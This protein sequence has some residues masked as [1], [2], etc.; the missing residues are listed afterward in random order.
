M[1]KRDSWAGVNNE[2]TIRRHLRSWITFGDCLELPKLTV[3]IADMT[4]RQHYYMQQAVSKPQRA[5]ECRQISHMGVLN[6]YVKHLPHQFTCG[7]DLSHLDLLYK[8]C[9]YDVTC[10]DK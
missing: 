4:K 5:T 8:T 9:W 2:K 3:F 6:D 1:H 7:V 10:G